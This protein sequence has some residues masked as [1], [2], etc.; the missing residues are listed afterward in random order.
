[1]PGKDLYY[2][3]QDKVGNVLYYDSYDKNTPMWWNIDQ[4]KAIANGGTDHLNNLNALQSA[5]NRSKGEKYD[6]Y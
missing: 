5:Q 1:V 6:N 3:S 2:Y 4:G